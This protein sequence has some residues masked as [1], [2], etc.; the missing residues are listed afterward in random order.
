[1]DSACRIVLFD[2]EK[3][4]ATQYAAQLR[5]R[6]TGREFEVE[7]LSEEV[8]A[9]AMSDLEK[10]RAASRDD[11]ASGRDCSSGGAAQVFDEAALLVLDYDLLR[12]SGIPCLS[13][14]VAAYLVRAYSTCGPIVVLNQ[15]RD[16]DFDLS[17]SG[18]MESS[19][20]L[21]LRGERLTDPGLW[22]D[23]NWSAFR[24]WHWPSLPFLIDRF[25]M[26]VERVRESLRDDPEIPV[27]RL[28]GLHAEDVAALSRQALDFVDVDWT[29]ER[30][31]E[32]A[33]QQKDRQ[34][35]VEIRARIAASRLS[36]W[37]EFVVLAGQ[38]VFVDL[39]H[40][41]ARFPSL[42]KKARVANR[43]DAWNE[44]LRGL[45]VPSALEDVLAAL[46]ECRVEM[47]PW[48][49]RPCWSWARLTEC[50]QIEEVR[51]PFCFEP[52]DWV[53]CEDSSRFVPTE[54]AKEFLSDLPGIFRRR[55]VERLANV[56]YANR[57]RLYA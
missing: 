55:Y 46:V 16:E 51:D 15:F 5:Q 43:C 34:A 52:V 57:A 11:S 49:S 47:G 29:I 21:D 26:M 24:P 42:M 35:N 23:R 37:L 31:V 2:D 44:T 14:G 6:V 39:P 41:V 50:L 10:R 48:L 33:L 56:E 1:M 19:A 20:D 40:L 45:A 4:P 13:G 36:R 22:D 8:F 18:H 38:D 3:E 27:G 7:A 54:Q 53:F 32:S 9:Q 30:V 12:T 28:L 17:M 25:P